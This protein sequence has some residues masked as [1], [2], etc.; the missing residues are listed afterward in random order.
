MDVTHNTYF[1][2]MCS[3]LFE[4]RCTI[5]FKR[6]SPL[7]KMTRML[8][9][10]GDLVQHGPSIMQAKK[11]SIVLFLVLEASQL[12]CN[13]YNPSSV[14]LK[15]LN[16]FCACAELFIKM[17]WK[18]VVTFL[19][20]IILWSYFHFFKYFHLPFFLLL[21]SIVLLVLFESPF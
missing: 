14:M 10:H 13:S 11:T 2:E 15:S 5:F 12:F 7:N 20:T 4:I 9:E 19:L 3:F 1:W 8:H 16:H 6:A 21:I 17:K 18:E